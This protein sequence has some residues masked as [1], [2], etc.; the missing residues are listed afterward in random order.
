KKSQRRLSYDF[1][2]Y[3]SLPV[4][5]EIQLRNLRPDKS[6]EQ[7]LADQVKNIKR[8]EEMALAFFFLAVEDV[9]PERLDELLEHDWLNAWAATLDVDRWEKNGLFNPRTEP[10]EMLST[11]ESIRKLFSPAPDGVIQASPAPGTLIEA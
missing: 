8:L 11:Y 9:M 1:L 3:L 6:S 7:L 4:M 5:T 10:G 2:D